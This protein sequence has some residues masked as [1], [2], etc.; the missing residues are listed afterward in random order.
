MAGKFGEE[1]KFGGLPGQSAFITASLNAR[2]CTLCVAIP[3]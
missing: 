3:H 2:H 1:V